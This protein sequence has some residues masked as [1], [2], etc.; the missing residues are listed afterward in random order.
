MKA[1]DKHLFL[2]RISPDSISD[3]NDV[4]WTSSMSQSLI[5]TK[6]PL[7]VRGKRLYPLLMEEGA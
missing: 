1:R 7:A 3:N 5:E 2:C 4:G 6:C